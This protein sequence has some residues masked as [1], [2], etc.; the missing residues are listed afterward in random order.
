MLEKFTLRLLPKGPEQRRL[1]RKL[2]MRE[3]YKTPKWKKYALLYGRKYRKTPKGKAYILEYNHRPEVVARHRE[4]ARTP[5]YRAVIKVWR[6]SP[7]GKK[8][9]HEYYLKN[10]EATRAYQQERYRI[11]RE[12]QGF[13]VRHYRPRV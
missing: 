2:Y 13:E 10:K 11:K 8:W 7:A 5:H 6:A 4:R 3:Y 1:Y 9:R 12:A